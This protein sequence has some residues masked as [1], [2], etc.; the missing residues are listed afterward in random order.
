ME[1]IFP[2]SGKPI[3]VIGPM[4][5]EIEYIA[6]KL[7]EPREISF[8]GYQFRSGTVDGYPVVAARS[9]IGMV[10][11]AVTTALAI[12]E[13]DP[14]MVIIQGTAGGHDPA[15]HK[16]D[17]ILGEHM[18]EIGNWYSPHRDA[19]RGTRIEDWFTPG[20][21]IMTEDG[22]RRFTVLKSHE[23]LL[24]AAEEV[25]YAKGKLVRGTI[26]SADLWD[27]EIDRILYLHRV[28]GSD[29]EEMEGFAVAQVCMEFHV[30]VL[31]IRVVSN[32]ELYPEEVFSEDSGVFCQEYVYNVIR[33]M[34]AKKS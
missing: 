3:V 30:P 2:L 21:E 33:N 8:G 4:A 20:E 16:N 26:G 22:I 27:K 6:S 9:L 5:C 15:R 29:A 31:H 19:G 25:P 18:V 23:E 7:S 10:N 1:K 14:A 12:R 11:S 28:T 34:I 24:R 17:I 32:S 13:F